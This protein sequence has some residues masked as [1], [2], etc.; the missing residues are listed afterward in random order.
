MSTT[1]S[2]L[3]Y[4]LTCPQA[5]SQLT[6][7]RYVDNLSKAHPPL[8]EKSD[9]E[10]Y[11]DTSLSRVPS[12]NCGHTFTVVVIPSVAFSVAPVGKPIAT[13]TNT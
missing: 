8:A 7:E 10:A 6:L 3:V 12:S 11:T 4:T 9:V 5:H 1:H 13:T 2:P